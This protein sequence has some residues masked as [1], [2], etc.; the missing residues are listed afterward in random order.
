MR[1]RTDARV[2]GLRTLYARLVR[3]FGPQHWWPAKTP[4][5]VMVGAILTQATRWH[6]VERALARLRAERALAPR[7]LLAL[8]PGRLARAVRP[9]GYFRQKARR[10]RTFTRWYAARYGGSPRRMFRTPWPA[11]RAE[12]LALHGIGP[13]TADSILLYAGGRPVFVV[14]A[15]TMRVFRR[16]RL[17]GPQA[18]YAD[19]QALAMRRLPADARLYNEF[20]ALL[21]AVGKQYCHRR[22]PAC[23]R[24]PLKTLPH[25]E[26]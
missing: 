12:L 11:L 3:A 1:G 19:V 17:I 4:F 8:P 5:E 15:Y 16:H 14:D 9:S 24:C 2:P 18:A 22:V 25:S 21:V 23:R 13:E 7:R 6:N 20:H 26:R 10:L